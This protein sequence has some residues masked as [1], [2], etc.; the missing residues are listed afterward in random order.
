MTVLLVSG[1]VM[2]LVGNSRN[3]E[4]GSSFTQSLKGHLYL[5]LGVCIN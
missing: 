2:G 5:L 4:G 3:D 1:L